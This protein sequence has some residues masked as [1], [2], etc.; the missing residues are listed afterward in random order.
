MRLLCSSVVA[1]HT[2]IE[3]APQF[4]QREIDL[5]RCLPCLLRGKSECEAA[6]AFSTTSLRERDPVQAVKEVPLINAAGL[7][8]QAYESFRGERDKQDAFL[9][10]LVE[11]RVLP[12]GLEW[13]LT[14]ACSAIQNQQMPR[15]IR[16]L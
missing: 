9:A 2:A 14:R 7:I 8:R 6:V 13:I 3:W 10:V 4:T 12:A 1:G 16:S 5:V 11:A 15:P